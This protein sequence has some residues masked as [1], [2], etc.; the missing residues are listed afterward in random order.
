MS[1]TEEKLE[2]IYENLEEIKKI[3]KEKGSEDKDNYEKEVIF[4]IE[5]FVR[6]FKAFRNYTIFGGFVRDFIYNVESLLPK[7]IFS[8]SEY[9]IKRCIV[10]NLIPNDIDIIFDGD[11][12]ELLK[13]FVPLMKNKCAIRYKEYKERVKNKIKEYKLSFEI[14]FRFYEYYERINPF[15]IKAD[16]IFSENLK[17]D[18]FD[19]NS[20][21]YSEEKGIHIHQDTKTL[22]YN[23]YNEYLLDLLNKNFPKDISKIILSMTNEFKAE[24]VLDIIKTNIKN[25]VCFCLYRGEK[26]TNIIERIIKMLDKGYKI[27]NLPISKC[28]NEKCFFHNDLSW[29]ECKNAI[30]KING[31]YYCDNHINDIIKKLF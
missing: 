3:L 2:K 21:L 29:V 26:V 31:K 15:D 30:L 9:R 8:E 11:E 18:D 10:N 22:I 7:K 25:K 14:Y 6:V 20:L 16:I 28:N 1:L 12:D 13:I 17:N 5:S 23:I 27:L 24:S 19:V 4:K